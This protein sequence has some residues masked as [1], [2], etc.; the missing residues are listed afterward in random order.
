M[1]GTGLSAGS[2]GRLPAEG[3]TQTKTNIDGLDTIHESI[4]ARHA[5]FEELAR[6]VEEEALMLDTCQKEG[7]ETNYLCGEQFRT[8]TESDENE[9]ALSPGRH[10]DT[11]LHI[12]K[13]VLQQTNTEVKPSFRRRSNCFG[14]LL[15]TDRK[16]TDQN[17]YRRAGCNT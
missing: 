4:R 10:N 16:N 6:R 7:E 13:N 15:H 2:G 9:E 11:T 3:K 5:R 14:G 17:K 8:K 12:V 1:G